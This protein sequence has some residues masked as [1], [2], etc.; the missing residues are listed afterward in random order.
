VRVASVILIAL[1]SLLGPTPAAG[2]PEVL[3][4]YAESDHLLP[5]MLHALESSRHGSTG[6]PLFQDLILLNQMLAEEDSESQLNNVVMYL[7]GGTR[8]RQL[9]AAGSDL[10]K[11]LIKRLR[12][13]TAYLRIDTNEVAGLL[14]CQFAFYDSLPRTT[15]DVFPLIR[16]LRP[17]RSLA[18]LNLAGNQYERQLIDAIRRLLPSANTPPRAIVTIDGRRASGK[19]LSLGDSVTLD[20]STSGDEDTPSDDL[21]YRWR[22][23]G[24]D[25]ALNP[26]PARKL[27]FAATAARIG[28]R[29]V[30]SG[31]YRFLCSV[32]DGIG[33][34][35]EELISITVEDSLE[36]TFQGR[37]MQ[38]LTDGLCFRSNYMACGRQVLAYAINSDSAD[39][40]L[41]RCEMNGRMISHVDQIV[42]RVPYPP[43][44]WDNSEV[45]ADDVDIGARVDAAEAEDRPTEERVLGMLTVTGDRQG[46]AGY[47]VATGCIDPGKYSMDFVAYGRNVVSGERRVELEYLVRAPYA[48]GVGLE[49]QDYV[50]GDTLGLVSR[51]RT[52]LVPEIRIFVQ[53][54]LLLDSRMYMRRLGRGGW[55]RDNRLGAGVSVMPGVYGPTRFGARID[56][57]L[58][59]DGRERPRW[60]G[61]VDAGVEMA[62]ELSAQ[63][64]VG[65]RMT[66]E[67]S[68]SADRNRWPRVAGG[69]LWRPT[70][71]PDSRV[72]N[73]LK[74]AAVLCVWGAWGGLFAR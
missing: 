14:E 69:L 6:Q 55:G 30:V 63:Y 1:F 57:R 15:A 52:E 38:W 49:N 25:G 74:G 12:D 46:R 73:V 70:V 48:F 31:Q 71:I 56:W 60:A 67:V 34:S 9:D 59:H 23:V 4:I 42:H 53:P 3:L 19:Y 2:R 40:A 24:T 37:R 45:S 16:S 33:R 32:S 29:P 8:A 22:Q 28:I 66:A 35:P 58:V 7:E 47:L 10:R 44:P 36:L 5:L 17:R 18:I 11:R 64:S 51:A 20:A 43:N 50:E 72:D 54:W 39:V 21:V 65:L 27:S 62:I 26:D 61:A 13:V 68:G 41:I